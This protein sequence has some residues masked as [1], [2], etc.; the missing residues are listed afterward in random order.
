M[1]PSGTAISSWGIGSAIGRRRTLPVPPKSGAMFMPQAWMLLLPTWRRAHATVAVYRLTIWWEAGL[2]VYLAWHTWRLVL[3]TQM[4][5]C[6]CCLSIFYILALHFFIVWCWLP[7]L[8]HSIVYNPHIFICL[9]FSLTCF[10]IAG[11]C[12]TLI[13]DLGSILDRIVVSTMHNTIT[14][15][16]FFFTCD[17]Q[18][19]FLWLVYLCLEFLILYKYNTIIAIVLQ[20]IVH[21]IVRALLSWYSFP[22]IKFI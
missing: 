4:L 5:I 19:L 13:I 1:L 7:F 22:Q 2:G 18:Q 10:Y 6:L 21:F 12:W 16:S 17:F 3:A 8:F 14:Y 11:Y 9:M 20:I 15:I